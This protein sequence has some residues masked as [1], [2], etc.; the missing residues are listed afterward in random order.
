M[1]WIKNLRR[2]RTNGSKLD[3]F[4][5]HAVNEILP[6]NLIECKNKDYTEFNSKFNLLNRFWL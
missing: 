4:I 5:I 6:F 1:F 3:I 2:F